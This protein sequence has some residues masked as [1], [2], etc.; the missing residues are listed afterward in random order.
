MES[1]KN[2]ITEAKVSLGRMLYHE[3]RLSKNQ[4]VSCKS[5]HDLAQPIGAFK[6]RL[7]TPARWDRFLQGGE[8]H[9]KPGAVKSFPATSDPGREA[10]T[11]QEGDRRILKVPFLRN[12]ERTAPYFHNG[13]ASTLE[14]AVRDMGEY[15]LGKTR[16]PGSEDRRDGVSRIARGGRSHGCREALYRFREAS[17]EYESRSRPGG[18]VAYSLR[19]DRR[20]PSGQ[21]ARR[22]TH[23]NQSV[24]RLLWLARFKI[25]VRLDPGPGRRIVPDN[26]RGR[27]L[28]GRADRIVEA[29][30][31][32][33]ARIG[34]RSQTS[35]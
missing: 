11:K 25:S 10:V 23:P 7:V 30:R 4:D 15:Q 3:P 26:A 1:Q 14:A 34:S 32:F 6:R 12:I 2:P 18:A 13:K 31:P 27:P 21:S 9:Q 29:N 5:C 24:A 8:M 28:S 22:C 17:V 35:A 20:G 16:P 33:W 19:G